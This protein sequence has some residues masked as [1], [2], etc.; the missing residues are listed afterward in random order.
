M[1]LLSALRA[2]LFGDADDAADASADDAPT[3]DEPVPEVEPSPGDQPAA[4]ADEPPQSELPPF[5][6]A[7]PGRQER[8]A[9]RILDDEGL[10]GDLTDDEFQPLLDW[11][12]AQTD[13]AAAATA[14]Q[15]DQAAD[16]A[17]DGAIM[18]IREV[19]R[20]AQDAV[21]AHAEGRVDDRRAA[22]DAIGAVWTDGM[23]SADEQPNPAIREQLTALADRLDAE[24]DLPGT[25]ITALI[26]AALSQTPADP[27]PADP[28]AAT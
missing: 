10:R 21:V 27:A 24:P 18:T 13:R 7:V 17:I 6:D 9:G 28:E 11:A 15:D 19:L 14:S 23:H 3:A 20:A 1:R 22:L 2:R 12:L 4:A 5:Q 25:E 8:A 16:A 26:A